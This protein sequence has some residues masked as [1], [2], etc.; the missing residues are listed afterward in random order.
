[1]STEPDAVAGLSALFARLAAQ[2]GLRLYSIEN[3]NGEARIMLDPE[4]DD[5]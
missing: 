5:E 2:E 1:M 4:G 3:E